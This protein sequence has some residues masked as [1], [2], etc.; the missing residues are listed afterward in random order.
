MRKRRWKAEPLLGGL[1][2]LLLLTGCFFVLRP[3]MT[4]LMWAIILAYSLHPMQRMFT[5][6]FRGSRTLAACFVTLTVTVLLAGPVVLIGVSLAQD[7]KDLATATRNWFMGVPDQPPAWVG[8]VPVVG[9]ELEVYW[10]GLAEDRKHWMDQLEQEVK[11]TP[12]RPKIVVETGDGLVVQDSSPPPAVDDEKNVDAEGRKDETQHLV[13]MLGRFLASVYSWLLTAGKAVVQGV[14]QV[15]VS[16][17]LAFFLL[18]D[19]SELSERLAVAVERLA[20]ERGRYLIKVAGD[21]VRGVIYGIL[22]TAIV[23]ALVAGLGFWIAGVPGAVLLAVLTFFF[24]VLP[25]GPPLIW[26]PASLWLFAQHKPGLG[27]FMLLWGF[28]GISSVD[29]FLRPYLISQGSK[30]PFV[31]IFCGVIG[32]AL[33]FGLVG[34]FLGPTLLAVVFR[35]VEEWSSNR[36]AHEADSAPDEISELPDGPGSVTPPH[37]GE[38]LGVG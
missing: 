24:A 6:W 30:M 18:R 12:P 27:V 32:G 26:L 33:A 2:L 1:A 17:F 22:G 9:D 25:F 4:A 37:G 36:S 5:R 20:G 10:T 29:N 38:S 11:T 19:A 15:L 13:A 16:A 35:L 28:L 21:T 3:F 23:Q 14:I 7:G 8:Q 34:V 31:L